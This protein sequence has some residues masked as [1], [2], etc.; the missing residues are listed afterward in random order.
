MNLYTYDYLENNGRLGNQL[1]QIAATIC[2]AEE[3]DGLARFKPDWEYRKFFSVPDFYF[4]A[5]DEVDEIIDGE[6]N[7]FQDYSLI[8][9]VEDLVRLYFKPS[10]EARDEM[11]SQWAN[12][13]FTDRDKLCAVHV[14]RGDYLKHGEKFFPIATSQYYNAAV[15]DVKK[16][17]EDI[18]FVVFSDDPQWCKDH[19][20]HFGFQS[21]DEVIWHTGVTRP[22]EVVDRKG[23]PADQWDMLAMTQM[24]EHIISNSTFSWWG[25]FL[26]NNPSP[27]YP[28]KWFGPRVPG[29]E[30][31]ENA[32]PGTWRKFTC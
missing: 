14:R 1:W 25:A 23:E 17:N 7:Y 19:P 6:T 2:R 29:Y 18:A 10:I 30:T 5:E 24:D 21:N 11:L 20:E 32:M 26:S 13:Y 22:V 12:D 9:P 3:N 31:W 4:I 8:E 28:S 27:I 15:S 16:R